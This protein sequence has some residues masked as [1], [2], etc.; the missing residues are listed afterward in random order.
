MLS[1]LLMAASLV[2]PDLH[3]CDLNG[4]KH[5]TDSLQGKPAVVLAGFTYES[6][7][8]MGAWVKA[9][10][11]FDP[12]IRLIEMPVYSGVA[13]LLRSLIDAGMAQH[14]PADQRSHVW[15]TTDRDKLV[16]AL[17]IDQPDASVALFVL[18]R[19]EKVVYMARGGPDPSK[20]RSCQ[21][22]IGTLLK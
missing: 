19:N 17:N 20:I 3:A 7:L 8:D 13:V 10:D 9:I 6:R 22:T 2:F 18:D 11:G 21:E 4:H 16:K 15:T 14:T 5:E 12:S 1:A